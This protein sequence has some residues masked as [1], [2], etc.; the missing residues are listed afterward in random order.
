MIFLAYLGC[1]GF[2]GWYGHANGDPNKLI[3]PVDGALNLCG[4]TPGF[5]DY[6]KLYITDFSSLN[7]NEIFSSAVCVKTCP[8]EYPFELDCAPNDNVASCEVEGDSQ[9]LTKNVLNYCFPASTD[10]IPDTV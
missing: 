8:Q 3:A 5:E 4:F 2:L 7:I 6:K 1:M 10:D 9:Y